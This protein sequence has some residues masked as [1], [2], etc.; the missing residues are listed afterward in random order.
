MGSYPAFSPLPQ[1]YKGTGKDFSPPIPRYGGYFLLRYYTLTDIESL[2][3][4]A[5]CV[6]RTFLP[7]LTQAAIEQPCY[8][9]LLHDVFDILDT[10]LRTYHTAIVI[11]YNLIAHIYRTTCTHPLIV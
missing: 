7:L 2:A 6:A 1:R 8:N 3:R 11:L 10:Q 5:L 4:A 9:Y